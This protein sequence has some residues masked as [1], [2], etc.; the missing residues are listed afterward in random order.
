MTVLN[1]QNDK[2]R[3]S[4]LEVTLADIWPSHAVCACVVHASASGCSP[5]NM[6]VEGF[7]G[8]FEAAD[9]FSESFDHLLSSR[10]CHR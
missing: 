8:P 1:S 9:S 6:F 10:I 3:I 4:E 2:N 5:T 7:A